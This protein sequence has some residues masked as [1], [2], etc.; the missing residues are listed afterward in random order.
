MGGKVKVKIDVVPHKFD[1]QR[2]RKRQG[3]KTILRPA[4]EKSR[5]LIESSENVEISNNQGRNIEAVSSNTVENIEVD[6]VPLNV[7]SHQKVTV[8]VQ[9]YF[10]FINP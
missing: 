6:S 2:N 5:I 1:C 10:V 4:A 9:E 7:K 8:E 3:T